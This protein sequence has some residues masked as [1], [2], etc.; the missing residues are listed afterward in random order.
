MKNIFKPNGYNSVSPY[1][2]VDGTKRLIDILVK[3][4]GA[5]EVRKYDMPDG[6]TVNR[7]CANRENVFGWQITKVRNVSFPKGLNE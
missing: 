7:L 1:F 5:E 2:V 6:T 4:F 3:I